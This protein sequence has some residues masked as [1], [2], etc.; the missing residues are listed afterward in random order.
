[1]YIGG[2]DSDGYH[3]LL[4][5]IVDNSVDEVING[6]AD[7]GRG[8]ARTRTARRVTVERQRPRHPGRHAPEVQE[9]GA[10]GDP[11]ARCTRAA[12]SRQ[13]NYVHSGG[14]HGVGASVVNALSSELDRRRS[15]ATASEYEQTFARG[16][17][18]GKLKKLGA[19]ARHRHDDHLRARRR[20]SSASKLRSTPS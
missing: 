7:A 4:W 6:H 2:I 12:S 1:M 9:A 17:P 8:H 15:S 16:K 20:R 5:E 18:T 19:G 3:H 14:L 11:H 13:S 10:R